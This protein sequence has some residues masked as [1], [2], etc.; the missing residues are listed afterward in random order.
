MA[1]IPF[2]YIIISSAGYFSR[3]EVILLRS[4]FFSETSGY[5]V[6]TVG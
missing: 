1:I 5:A 3:K 2:L 4:D 6:P